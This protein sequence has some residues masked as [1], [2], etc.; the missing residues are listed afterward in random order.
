[1]A[2]RH[3]SPV[4]RRIGGGFSGAVLFSFAPAIDEDGRKGKA[5]VGVPILAEEFQFHFSQFLD[6]SMPEGVGQ[7]LSNRR[8]TDR[9]EIRRWV[10]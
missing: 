10:G 9:G 5:A 4:G 8:S 7:P 6:F 2:S 1:M 3:G